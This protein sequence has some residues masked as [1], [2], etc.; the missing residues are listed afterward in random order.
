MLRRMNELVIQAANDSNS[1]SDR[2]AIQQEINLLVQEI[3]QIS[4]D[5][6]FN[7][8]PV[9][10]GENVQT[11]DTVN[12]LT[13]SLPL[14]TNVAI[15]SSNIDLL[16]NRNADGSYELQD[17]HTYTFDRNI[18][19]ATFHMEMGQLYPFKTLF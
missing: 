19:N 13:L 7:T 9:F 8:M 16:L 4:T 12:D 11:A 18:T 1:Y 15:N 5:T 14:G 10:N 2:D 17:G 3:E 6:T